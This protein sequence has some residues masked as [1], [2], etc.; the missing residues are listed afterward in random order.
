MGLDFFKWP[1]R[2]SF[3]ESAEPDSSPE[4]VTNHAWLDVLHEHP[5]TPDEPVEEFAAYFQCLEEAVRARQ[6]VDISPSRRVRPSSPLYTLD[7][8][9]AAQKAEE[10]FRA[11]FEHEDWVDQERGAMRE[12]WRTVPHS[13][14]K[15]SFKHEES[16]DTPATI[17][18]SAESKLSVKETIHN[19]DLINL[20]DY[21][22]SHSPTPPDDGGAAAL[23]AEARL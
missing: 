23:V 1:L 11:V 17:F 12:V 7:D 2:S 22:R 10:I 15:L 3:T 20:D 6:Y 14:M 21:R 4:I 19:A 9:I 16:L 13:L 18:R 5:P 8:E